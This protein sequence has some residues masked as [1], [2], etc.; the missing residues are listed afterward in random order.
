MKNLNKTGW[1]VKRMRIQM[2][3]MVI[4]M[5]MKLMMKMKKDVKIF[6]L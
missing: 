1:I 4:L 5:S 6:W 3:V 2:V